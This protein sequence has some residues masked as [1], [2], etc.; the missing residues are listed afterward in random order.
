VSPSSERT[1]ARLEALRQAPGDVHVVAYTEQELAEREPLAAAK[2]LGRA[3]RRGAP[4]SVRV[5]LL[6]RL[7]VYLG[8]TERHSCRIQ[9][10]LLKR[11]LSGGFQVR[12]MGDMVELAPGWYTSADHEPFEL[13]RRIPSRAPDARR[14]D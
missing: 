12:W 11:T 7:G 9:D 5:K 14:S 10:A 4:R 8:P 6:S 1:R 3:W 13:T 2:A